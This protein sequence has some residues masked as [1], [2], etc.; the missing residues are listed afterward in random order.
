MF[1]GCAASQLDLSLKHIPL[2]QAAQQHEALPVVVGIDSFVDLRPQL[3]GDDN[4]K[5][6]GFIPGILWIDIDS[7][8][9]ELYTS[10]APYNSR[11]FNQTVAEGITDALER[12]GLV[13]TVAY[14]PADPYRF[15][16]YRLEGVLRRSLVKETSYYYGSCM[17]VWVFRSFGLPY[18]S[19]D[20]TLEF[21]LGL[22][23]M[24]SNQIVWQ[25]RVDGS[26]EDRYKTVYSLAQGTQGKHVIAYNFSMILAEKLPSLFADMQR[27]LAHD[28]QGAALNAEP[29]GLSR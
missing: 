15:V 22:R 26:I 28:R 6:L 19:Y 1:G 24:K 12:S 27:A 4:K 18:V 14:M 5:W 10:C 17:Y 21:D 2:Q 25:G 7:D 29:G 16:D 13:Q 11:P 23:N 20:M 3:H 9:P 8:I